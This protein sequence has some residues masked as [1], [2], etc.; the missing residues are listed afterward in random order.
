MVGYI[1][2]RDFFTLGG[3]AYSVSRASY[4]ITWKGANGFG[5]LSFLIYMCLSVC[6]L[7]GR[8]VALRLDI[9][10]LDLF[11]RDLYLR[12]WHT[13]VH[14]LYIYIYIYLFCVAYVS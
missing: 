8:S 4:G 12:T 9:A 2:G 5:F 7:V 3:E 14:T 11:A 6:L 13:Y 1:P 10:V